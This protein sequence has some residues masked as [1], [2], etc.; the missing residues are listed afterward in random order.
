L[1]GFVIDNQVTPL[2]GSVIYGVTNV[3]AGVSTRYFNTLDP[4]QT[5]HYTIANP[6]TLVSG[7][8]ISV[9]FVSSKVQSS[10][11]PLF[12]GNV[13]SRITARSGSVATE[14]NFAG[15][16]N[17]AVDGIPTVNGDTFPTD[18][19]IHTLTATIAVTGVVQFVGCNFAVNTFFDGIIA[20]VK[21]TDLETQSDINGLASQR[22]TYGDLTPTQSSSIAAFTLSS[23]D[24]PSLTGTVVDRNDAN[25]TY[26]GG[27]VAASGVSYPKT[28]FNTLNTLSY[29]G[30]EEGAASG[31]IE[32]STDASK[33]EMRFYKTR[34]AI[35]I[36]VDGV[37][38]GTY[39]NTVSSGQLRYLLID[40]TPLGLSGTHRIRLEFGGGAFIG[41]LVLDSGATLSS[42]PALG[43]T[44]CYLGDS[45]T[46]GTG[47]TY[48][49]ASNSYVGVSAKQLGFNDYA[50]SGFG[51]TGWLKT[52]YPGFGSIRPALIT[53]AQW[54]AVGYDNYV[55]AMGIN[56][57]DADITASINTTLDTIQAANIGKPIFVLGSWGNG[58]GGN[59]KPLIESS[60]VSATTGRSHVHYIQ[61]YQVSFTKSDATHP[62][63]AGHKTLGDYIAQ[64][65]KAISATTTFALDTPVGDIEY[66]EENVF[67]SELWS[68]P[69]TS[70]GNAWVYDGGG[71][72]SRSS[73]TVGSD[74]SI[75]ATTVAQGTPILI[76]VT[77]DVFTSSGL[78]VRYQGGDNVSIP[79]SV[80]THSV[81]AIAGAV[82]TTRVRGDSSFEGT[83]SN[84]SIREIS[85]AVQYI[86]IPD[87][88][89][90]TP[91][92][93]EFQFDSG[94]NQ[95][96]N[97]SPPPQTLPSILE[98]P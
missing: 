54:D 16:T 91:A 94:L 90:A 40:L 69:A 67:G 22:S 53:R 65:I 88:N 20:N 38:A 17:V 18:G 9:E 93:E 73:P 52:N 39:D 26:W 61:V 47:V 66:S 78:V 42:S 59:I 8:S 2:N 10:F 77:I 31:G 98:L 12:D 81:V 95:W 96:D 70:I 37:F 6:I 87:I 15:L 36:L 35:R 29:S 50:T 76:T 79:N 64:Q 51:G 13:G 43:E 24:A 63:E 4:I 68:D 33:F 89:E 83:I 7:D 30:A 3:L 46:E 44:I 27:R 5:S 75:S 71:V 58:D 25:I 11:T 34:Q 92:R 97:I 48:E 55:I 19:K 49:T 74:I 32:F 28:L 21:F 14:W 80:G 84:I 57:T 41:D 60:I 62:D 23:V 45:F 86:G 56:D 72:Y 1:T 85:N 82:G